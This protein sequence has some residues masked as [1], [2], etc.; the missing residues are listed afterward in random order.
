MRAVLRDRRHNS[1]PFDY[2]EA[3]STRSEL[4]RA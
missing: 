4:P 1:R 2:A 3:N